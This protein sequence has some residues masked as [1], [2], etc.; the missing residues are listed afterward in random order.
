MTDVTTDDPSQE[1][2]G[3]PGAGSTT[4]T[5]TAPA[6]RT[7]APRTVRPVFT[8]FTPTR[9]RAHTLHRVYDSLR[10][11]TFRDFE[12]LLI[13]NESSDGTEELVAGWTAEA[14]FA[15][16]YIRQV[17]RGLTPSWNREI[18]EAHGELLVTLASDDTCYPH[19]LERLWE[20][21]QEIPADRRAS[22]ASLA[23]LCVDEH[24][25]L[26]GDPFPASPLD[27]STIE[28][29]LRHHVRG[30]KW[31][32]QR[33][34]VLRQFPFP[35]IDGYLGYIPEGIVWN[36]VG[37]RYKERCVNEVLR[38]FWL[39]AP[40]SLA[41]PRF[42][43]DNALGG[44][45]KAEDLLV[46]DIAYL[47]SAPGEFLRAGVRYSRFSF[48]LGRGLGTQAR[49]LPTGRARALWV[50]TLPLGFARWLLDLRR[51]RERRSMWLPPQEPG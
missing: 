50:G 24:G 33:V 42:A 18:A 39:D 34:D 13:D 23:T 36:A 27:T 11:Q 4:P 28:L 35:V 20:L 41:R 8:V 14:D 1:A 2:G 45:L 7:A 31:G 44:T 12:W 6:E 21:W 9:N 40:V 48:H 16:R 3:R 32:C 30:E 47:R 5:D 46:N 37:R 19:A 38:Q 17:N 49:R 22:F 15:V 29:R 10:A 43:G 25:T 51:W 26:I